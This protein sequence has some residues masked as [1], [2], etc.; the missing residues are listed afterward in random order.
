MRRDQNEI[1]IA[2]ERFC[3]AYVRLDGNADAAFEESFGRS[4]SSCGWSNTH[5]IMARPGVILRIHQLRQELSEHLRV[6]REAVADELAEIAFS[7][8]ADFWIMTL[9]RS[10][11]RT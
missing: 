3:D 1:T 6:D 11:S 2:E 4:Q 9:K 5:R 8:I 7:N 10:R